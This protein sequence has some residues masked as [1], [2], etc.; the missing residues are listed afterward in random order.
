MKEKPHPKVRWSIDGPGELSYEASSEDRSQVLRAV[1]DAA[2]TKLYPDIPG[3]GREEAL[4]VVLE[5]IQIFHDVDNEDGSSITEWA[6]DACGF[7]S[8]ERGKV[9]VG[10]AAIE[11]RKEEPNP[12]TILRNVR[13][14]A[15]HMGI[16]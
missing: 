5:H 7:S 1:V 6:L 14:A 8:D 9:Y 3:G 11:A 15:S 2:R 16:E 10:I 12:E 13:Q 4:G